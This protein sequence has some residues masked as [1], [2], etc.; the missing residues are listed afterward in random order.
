MKKR[1]KFIKKA[2]EKVAEA[3]KSRDM[4][5]SGVTK[6]IDDLDKIINLLGERL[7][8]WYGIYYPE[9]ALA[10]R[11][12]YAELVAFIDRQN[13]DTKELASI[14]GQ[15][16]ADEIANKAQSSLGAQLN[17][18]DL[19]QIRSLA[20]SIMNL[21]KL[22]T[23][24]ETHQEE[25]ALDIC[26]NMSKVAGAD[27]AAKLVS[28]VGSLKRLCRLPASTIQVLGAEK[29]L[30][31][32]LKNRKVRPPKHGIIFQHP[33]IAGSPK[34]IRGKIARALA[35]KISLASKADGITKRDMGEELLQDFEKRFKDIVEK[36]KKEK[37][38]SKEEN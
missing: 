3:L 5:L 27:I 2:K 36:Y 25:L 31:K 15:K 17:E 21:D 29:A 12:K 35:N 20:A 1:E 18:S 14:V 16:K 28:H 37:S 13:I 30:F 33:K 32:H 10:D 38:K 11:I 23:Q 7:E 26:P 34:A 9:L 19:N 8:E 6:T 22:R 24:Y 4:L